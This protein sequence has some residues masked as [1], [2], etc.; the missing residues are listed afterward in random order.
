MKEH[1]TKLSIDIKF[2]DHN[3]IDSFYRAI[4]N[5]NENLEFGIE[6]MDDGNAPYTED[7]TEQY[8]AMGVINVDTV[9]DKVANKSW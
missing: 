5:I 8:E 3:E 6:I 7:M 2:T 1:V 4:Q 9:E